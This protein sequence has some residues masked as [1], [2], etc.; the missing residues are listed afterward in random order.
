MVR[1]RKFDL[2]SAELAAV[3]GHEW[4]DPHAFDGF[5]VTMQRVEFAAL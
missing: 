3:V 2:S 4:I 1:D 5:A